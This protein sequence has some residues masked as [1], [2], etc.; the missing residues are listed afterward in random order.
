MYYEMLGMCGGTKEGTGRNDP[1]IFSTFNI[2]PIGVA[3]PESTSNSPRPLQSSRRGAVIGA[4]NQ[5]RYST[6]DEINI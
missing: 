5:D 6:R 2:R 3:W 4:G 1:A